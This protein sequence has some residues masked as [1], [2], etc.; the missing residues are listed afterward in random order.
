MIN[1]TDLVQISSVLLEL[2]VCVCVCVLRWG[3]AR[4]E[5]AVR[6]KEEENKTKQPNS[7]DLWFSS[8]GLKQGLGGLSKALSPNC[9]TVKDWVELG[10]VLRTKSQLRVPC[11]AGKGRQ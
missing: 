4:E 11:L 8:C 3:E 10:R 7:K 2:C 1:F 6:G 5:G 9:G